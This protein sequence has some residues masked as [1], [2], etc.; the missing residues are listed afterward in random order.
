[1]RIAISGT[2]RSG[3]STLLED[4]A[5]VLPAYTAIEEPYHQL[6]EEGYEFA[7]APSLEDFVE[8]LER[9]I[10]CLQE[11]EADILFDRCPA[12][13]LGYLLA[14]EDSEAFD[15]EDWLPRVRAAVQTLDLI[16]FVPVEGRDRIALS[17]SEDNAF[18]LD[19]DDRLRTVL[20]EDPYDLHA[21]VLEVA[22]DRKT[23]V[24]QVLERIKEQA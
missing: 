17:A 2:H 19:V 5:E 1:M 21:E 13:F 16:V 22:G 23:R 7:E 8:Q 18:R 15:I 12:D 14:H 9:S 11:S 24:K 20:F 6:A 4:L 10:L 3:K